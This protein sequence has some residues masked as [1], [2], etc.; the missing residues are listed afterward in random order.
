MVLAPLGDDFRWDSGKE[1]DDQFNNYQMIM[2][3]I[4]KTPELHAEVSFWIISH[5]YL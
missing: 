2:D 4:N 5:C 1:W 3:Y